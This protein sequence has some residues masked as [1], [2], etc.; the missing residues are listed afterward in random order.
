MANVGVIIPV[1]NRSTTVLEALDSVAAQTVPPRSL[2]V[3]TTDRPTA[4]PGPSSNGWQR[5]PLSFP[6][7]CC[8]KRT[9]GLRPRRD[10]GTEESGPCELFAFLDSDDLWPCDFLERTCGALANRP[11]AVAATCDGGYAVHDNCAASFSEP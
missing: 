8:D 2:V 5:N 7:A 6:N 4:P 11:E 3:V 10:R 9:G 1:Y